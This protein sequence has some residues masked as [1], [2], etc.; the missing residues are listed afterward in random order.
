[1][2]MP[3]RSKRANTLRLVFFAVLFIVELSL[4]A[5]IFVPFGR[6]GSVSVP[7]EGHWQQ[8]VPFGN[9][10]WLPFAAIAMVVVFA[11]A[12]VGLLITI[13]RTAKYLS[14]IGH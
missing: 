13:W 3:A 9:A 8:E 7:V 6:F 2:Q 11:M 12:N 5:V 1:M 4:I 10:W 14:K